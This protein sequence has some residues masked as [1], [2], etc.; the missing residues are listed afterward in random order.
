MRAAPNA[1][2]ARRAIRAARLSPY[3]RIAQ[4]A[5]GPIAGS[6]RQFQGRSGLRAAFTAAGVDFDR[7]LVT[8]CGSGVTA[9]TVMFGAWLLG[10]R[11]MA[12]YDGSWSEWGASDDTP[13]EMGAA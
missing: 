3:P 4:P 7:P 8:T 10:K 5:D 11:D 2:R 12:L 9:A 1:F 13:K 6:R